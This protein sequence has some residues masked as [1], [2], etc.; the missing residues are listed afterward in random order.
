M[1]SRFLSLVVVFLV[2]MGLLVGVMQVTAVQDTSQ[3]SAPYDSPD[4][5][6]AATL[7]DEQPLAVG[8]PVTFR[9][10]VTNT[11][12]AVIS[13]EVPVD[14]V[15]NPTAVFTDSV[16]GWV[17]G[18]VT[19]V[20]P[21][22]GFPQTFTLT[23]R[24]MLGV[25]QHQFYAWA[26]PERTITETDETNNIAGPLTLTVS[27]E[28][29]LNRLNPSGI[30]ANR[31]DDAVLNTQTSM[32]FGPESCTSMGDP[33]SPINSPWDSGLYTYTY[34]IRIPADYPHDVVRV[35]LFDPDSINQPGDTFEIQHTQLAVDQGMPYFE[36][37]ACP[38]INNYNLQYQPCLINTGESGLG[39]PLDEINLYWFVRS[40]E[41]RRPATPGTNSGCGAPPGGVYTPAYNTRTAYQ[42]YYLAQGPDDAAARVHLAAYMGQV[43]DG[44]R[45]NGDHLTDMQWVSP[46]APASVGQ[47]AEAPTVCGSPNGGDY[48]PVACPGGTPPGAGSGFEVDLTQ[49]VPG[50]VTDPVSGDRFLYV[51]VTT[52]SGSSENGFAIWAG[53]NTYVNDVPSD[54]NL[55]NLYILDDHAS[56]SPEGV[57]VYALDYLPLNSNIDFRVD[58]PLIDLGPEYAGETIEVAHFDSDSGSY[59]PAHFYVDTLA[60]DDWHWTTPYPD[61]TGRC[62]IGSCNNQWTTPPYTITLPTI[63]DCD[64]LNP[65]DP[66]TCTPFYGGRLMVSYE[67]G[68]SDSYAWH[69]AVPD[70]P[71]I[72]PTASC[73]AMPVAVN[74]LARSVTSD[75]FPD[76]SDFAYPP[77]PPT[78]DD[79][80]YNH[81]DIPLTEAQP[82][83]VFWVY[84]G[85]N[86]E[87]FGWLRWNE[88]VVGGS[89]TL[90]DSLTW[91]G[92]T[93]DYSNHGEHSI[94]P[95]TP[96][97]P[98]IV[99]GYVN[100]Y[101]NIDLSLNVGD[102]VWANTAVSNSSSVRSKLNQHI[103]L[104]RPLRLLIWDEVI[105]SYSNMKYRTARFAIFR[106][107]GYRLDNGWLLLEFVQ[108]DDSCG[109]TQ[110]AAESVTISG[111]EQGFATQPYTFTA[112]I[113]PTNSTTPITYT[114]QAAGQTPIT[115]TGGIT[116]TASWTW[117]VTGTYGIT[118]TAVSPLNTVTATHAIT[119]EEAFTLTTMS[120]GSGSV[121]LSPN[122]PVYPSG[123]VVTLTAVPDP[124]WIF[125]GWGDDLSGSTNP[126]VVTMDADK[127]ISAYFEEDGVIVVG[128]SHP[129]Q[130]MVGEVVTF[131]VTISPE[132]IITPITYTWQTAGQETITHTGG[133]SDTVSFVWDEWGEMEV[134]LTAVSRFNT[135]NDTYTMTIP[136]NPWRY[137]FP[138]MLK[139]N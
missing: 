10:V 58:I 99:R 48:D 11:G 66:Q 124:S 3:P 139:P 5:V 109:Q 23:T 110:A 44:V 138:I 60:F 129:A 24:L 45:D 137:Y 50:M 89:G 81:P 125:V 86:D 136:I 2:V 75:T 6:V 12:T 130:A 131:A 67:A 22:I 59:P 92:N 98:Y 52:V 118:V 34:R 19:A 87:N 128:I 27:A 132:T 77:D 32:V 134:V 18:S 30:Y 25:G 107:A 4:L 13:G 7:L 63:A 80:P 21:T 95:A 115:H 94:F 126:A 62:Q 17:V 82:G 79:F 116:D 36:T 84:E 111:A 20:S 57:T 119:I 70:A 91:P 41:N 29:S 123:T 8:Q 72:D 78:Y 56:H 127:T 31:R 71:Q 64:W 104:S 9:V 28:P 14:I 102:W 37:L 35:E 74:V 133:L 96:L 73:A 40:D 122:L 108:W 26:D 61:D 42:L 85:F 16:E 1:K 38:S 135:L 53:P 112:V 33:F 39:F 55:R 49:D 43:N 97:Y 90:A 114:W 106:L 103:D 88:G 121:E 120:F 65:V 69:A 83:D 93:L 68:S 76:P 117:P 15:I 46:G 100:P 54:V 101:N 51:D 47:P 105:G 113:T